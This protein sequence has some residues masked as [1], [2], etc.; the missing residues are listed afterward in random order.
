MLYIYNSS[1]M[2]IQWR[3]KT[4]RWKKREIWYLKQKKKKIKKKQEE[5]QVEEASGVCVFGWQVGR[6]ENMGSEGT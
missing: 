4:K 3:I 6:R 5:E 1:S 2:I